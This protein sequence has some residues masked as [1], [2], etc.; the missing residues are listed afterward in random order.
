MKTSAQKQFAKNP[1]RYRD[2]PLFSAGKDLEFMVNSVSLQG[3]EVLLDVGSGAGHTAIAFSPFVKHCTG[4]D[5]TEEMVQTAALFAKEKNAFRVSFLQ[6]DAEKLDFPDASFDIVTCRFA[7]HHFPDIRRAVAE[8]ARVLKSGGSF[9][10]V[11]HYAP[12]DK[13]LDQFINQLNQMRDPSHVREY[14]LAEWNE[15][16]EENGL[17]Y[18][19][20]QKW[21]IPIDFENWIRR[22]A[23][24]EEKRPDIIAHLTGSSPACRDEFEIVQNDKGEPVS[25][26]LKGIL[27]V[28]RKR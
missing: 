3:D 26:K 12:E 17:D 5:I 18:I 10:L 23:V 21:N 8:I 19:E 25:F 11:D 2:E 7:A 1:D 16:F 27:I 14:S 15:W 22:G 9:I 28:G 13:A 4:V 20:K 24:P 6:G